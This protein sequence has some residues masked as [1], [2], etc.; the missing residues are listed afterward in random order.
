M[1]VSNKQTRKQNKLKAKS[2]G[3]LLTVKLNVGITLKSEIFTAAYVV[4]QTIR[5]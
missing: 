5:I 2:L 3:L 4:L 1:F